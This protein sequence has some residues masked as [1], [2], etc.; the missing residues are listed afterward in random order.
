MSFAI[1]RLKTKLSRGSRRIGR[2]S[3]IFAWSVT[4]CL[5]LYR[6]FYKFSSLKHIFH[7]FLELSLSES[8]WL[9]KS[10]LA[11]LYCHLIIN[12]PDSIDCSFVLVSRI[13]VFS[14]SSAK[15]ADD[16]ETERVESDEQQQE[17]L[18]NYRQCLV[19]S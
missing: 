14:V 9:G 3:S 8:I 2:Y 13:V 12:K 5:R 6:N 10:R 19:N 11:R 18:N 1:F 15:L 4:L 16:E 7:A 17:Y